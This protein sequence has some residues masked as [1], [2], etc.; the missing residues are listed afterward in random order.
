MIQP[1]GVP[2]FD[3]LA[4]A[5]ERV[6]QGS[7]PF[8]TQAAATLATTTYLQS[9]ISAAAANNVAVPNLVSALAAIRATGNP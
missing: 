6:L 2:A 4:L 9:V 5:A 3:A 1:V 7:K 8:A